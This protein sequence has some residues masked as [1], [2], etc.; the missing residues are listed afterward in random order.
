MQR[1][2]A[3]T[4]VILFSLTACSGKKQETPLSPDDREDLYETAIT[5]ARSQEINEV[6]PLIDDAE[7]DLAQP[8][9]ALLGI[10]PADMTAYAISVS[11]MNVK[12]Y[13]VAAIY[14]AAGKEDAILDALRGFVD[15]QV[16]SFKQYLADQHEIAINSR[17][18]TLEDGTVLL[19]MCENQDAVFDA[20]KDVIEHGRE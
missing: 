2:I 1:I 8:V 14:P 19:V 7:D 4:F 9:F 12:A 15:D 3:W 6:Y 16:Q 20:V 13:A 5:A 18:E 10:S 17:L 11:L